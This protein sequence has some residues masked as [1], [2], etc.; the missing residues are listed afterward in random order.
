MG[1]TT[2]ASSRNFSRHRVTANQYAR[3][4]PKTN[5]V[6]VV[7]DANCTLSQIASKSM[8]ILLEPGAMPAQNHPAAITEHEVAQRLGGG[9]IPRPRQDHPSLLPVRISHK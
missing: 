2:M 7:H 3:G 6:T 9:S 8:I 4:S 5:K 1:S